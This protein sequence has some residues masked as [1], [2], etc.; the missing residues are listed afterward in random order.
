M[1]DISNINDYQ[2][3]DSA[4]GEDIDKLMEDLS[5]DEDL[6][7]DDGDDGDSSDD[8]TS[9]ED[10]TGS[11]TKLISLFMAYCKNQT[12]GPLRPPGPFRTRLHVEF[13]P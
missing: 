5:K 11:G 6:E 4:G 7:G 10:S 8:L 2:D 12:L 9:E 13:S 1:S 3:D